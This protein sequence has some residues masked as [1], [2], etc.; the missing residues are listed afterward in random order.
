VIWG[1]IHGSGLALERLITGRHEPASARSVLAVWLNRIL[2]FNVVCLAWIFFREP[3]LHGALAQLAGLAYW[4]WQP[5]YGVALLFLSVFA[6]LLL[7]IDLQLESAATEYLCADR[8]L[9]IRVT[10][11]VLFCVLITLLGA[12]QANAFIYFRF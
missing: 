12:N 5:V 4:K 8:S 3:S 7:A 1:G 2:I 11:G 9:P 10:I 6:G